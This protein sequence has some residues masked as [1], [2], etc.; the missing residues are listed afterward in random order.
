MEQYDVIIVGLGCVG[1]AAAYYCAK[2]GLKVLGIEQY[3]RPG[4]IG[5]SSFGETRLWRTTHDV[6]IRNDMMWDSLPLWKELEE[7]SGEKLVLTFPVLTIG[8]GKF[9]NDIIEQF[10]DAPLMTPEEITEQFP[11]LA[12]IPSN[13]KG[14]LN[15]D[16]GIVKA[17]LAMLSAK[18]LAEEKY[19]ATLLFNTK[20]KNVKKDSVTTFDGTTYSAKSVVV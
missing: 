19:G 10:P 12:N 13:Y 18:K 20:V 3:S 11:T 15:Q 5:T 6:K 7:E 8:V 17:R 2:K 16:G 1:T 14:L 4:H 9:F